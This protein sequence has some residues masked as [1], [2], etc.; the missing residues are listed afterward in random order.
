MFRKKE[1]TYFYCFFWYSDIEQKLVGFCQK[2]IR[3]ICKNCL[4]RVHTNILLKNRFYGKFF[5]FV[6]WA[7]FPCFGPTIYRKVVKAIFY[8]FRQ[9]FVET[10][11][12]KPFL[13]LVHN[14]TLSTIF[15]RFGWKF[16]S[17]WQSFLRIQTKTL[18]EST[19][20]DKSFVFWILVE[21]FFW[22]SAKILGNN[23]Q[24]CFLRVHETFWRKK[25]IG[26]FVFGTYLDFEQ[27]IPY[28]WL[29]I[30]H[31]VDKTA[32]WRFKPTLWRKTFLKNFSIFWTL[33]ETFSD[34]REFFSQS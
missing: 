17:K 5:F 28:I 18:M 30:F 14:L 20:F 32:F 6:I 22:L 9:H 4:L 29:K 23:C 13:F 11:F 31:K 33:V 26:F 19:F 27:K 10:D 3:R 2:E 21:T 34:F 1:G 12:F 7:K 15:L 8:M 16:S 24:N 25:F